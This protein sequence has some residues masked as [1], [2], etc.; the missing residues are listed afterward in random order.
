MK[1]TLLSAFAASLCLSLSAQQ[2][3]L[4]AEANFAMPANQV[5]TTGLEFTPLKQGSNFKPTAT[6]HYKSATET[7]IGESFYDL[8]T[9]AAVQNRLLR[10]DDGTTSG[11]MTWSNEVANFTVRG[12][13]YNY[14]DAS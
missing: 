2:A 6:S 14:E 9:N 12:T 3:K 1:Q 10:H 11:G 7:V 8:Q 4:P 5:A 13:A